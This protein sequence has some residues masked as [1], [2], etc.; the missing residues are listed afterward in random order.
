MAG[1]L[2]KGREAGSGPCGG[3]DAERGERFVAEGVAEI[4]QHEPASAE[5]AERGDLLDDLVGT[6]LALVGRDAD[7]GVDAAARGGQL[8]LGVRSM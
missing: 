1:L 7:A 8:E 6:E 4:E 5:A 3:A 2:V